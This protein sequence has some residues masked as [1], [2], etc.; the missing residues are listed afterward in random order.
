[1]LKEETRPKRTG[2]GDAGQRTK[3]KD[4]KADLP[5]A[6]QML[7]PTSSR[8]QRGVVL[9]PQLAQLS[10]PTAPRARFLFPPGIAALATGLPPSPALCSA[11]LSFTAAVA[12]VVAGAEV[13]DEVTWPFELATADKVLL[14]VG[15]PE[16]AELPPVPSQ[17]PSP[18][19]VPARCVC[20]CFPTSPLVAGLSLSCAGV[21]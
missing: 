2:R 16:H 1:M 8:L 13:G 12:V 6:L 18:G 17:R 14:Y 21:L 11:S 9:V 10:A 20:F 7:F 15:Q 19:H 3:R 4:N 5:Q